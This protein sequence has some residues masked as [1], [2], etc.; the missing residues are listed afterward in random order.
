[1]RVMEFVGLPQAFIHNQVRAALHMFPTNAFQHDYSVTYAAQGA[2]QQQG[3][4]EPLAACGQNKLC[5]VG[6]ASCRLK[7]STAAVQS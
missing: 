2:L 5:R 3:M 1:M 4:C 6:F 7:A